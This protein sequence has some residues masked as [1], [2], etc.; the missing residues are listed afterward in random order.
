MNQLGCETVFGVLR[1][2]G[3]HAT[4]CG[5][6]SELQEVY[7]IDFER[8][9]QLGQQAGCFYWAFK[10]QASFVESFNEMNLCSSTNAFPWATH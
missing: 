3:A 9:I 2:A 5:V 1:C 4:F 10:P 7:N 8:F 6:C